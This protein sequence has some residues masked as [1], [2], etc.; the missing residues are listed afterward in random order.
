MNWLLPESKN[1]INSPEQYRNLLEDFMDRKITTEQYMNAIPQE[2]KDTINQMVEEKGLELDLTIATI[3]YVVT[4]N[5]KKLDQ[6][7]AEK[8]VEDLENE[9][10]QDL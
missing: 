8:A 6:F 2:Q 5:I 7:L 10:L 4:K 3:H 9:D 1:F